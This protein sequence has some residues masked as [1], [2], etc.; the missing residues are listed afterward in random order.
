[1][2][3]RIKIKVRIEELRKRYEN[4]Q[5]ICNSG[6]RISPKTVENYARQIEKLQSYLD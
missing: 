2:R 1:M 4:L 3:E 6:A 5:R